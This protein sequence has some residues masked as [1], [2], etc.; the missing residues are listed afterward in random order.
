MARL[1]YID[2][3]LLYRYSITALYNCSYDKC[4]LPAEQFNYETVFPELSGSI[5][6][7]AG[8][9]V[10]GEVDI[11]RVPASFLSKI[12]KQEWSGENIVFDNSLECINDALV[13]KI[14][15]ISARAGIP[16]QKFF[17][18]T[19]CFNPV[20][21]YNNLELPPG[22]R[23]NVAGISYWEYRFNTN[24]DRLYTTGPKDRLLLCF[25]RRL[26]PHRVLLISKLL[27][28]D[29]V[30]RSLI[31]FSAQHISKSG[32][33]LSD[34]PVFEH[35][36]NILDAITQ[37]EA[38][39]ILKEYWDIFPLKLN[40]DLALNKNYLDSDDIELYDRSYFS[41]VTETYFFESNRPIFHTEKIFKP[42]AM[43]HPFIVM[44]V[45]GILDAFKQL[46]YRSFHPYI[47]ETYDTVE[48]NLDRFNCITA[49]IE[50]LSKFTDSEWIEWQ[51]NIQ[52]IVEFNY[53][54]LNKR[55]SMPVSSIVTQRNF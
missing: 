30:N 26:A 39:D 4:K 6:F 43:R 23:C 8:P 18:I 55:K 35:C 31:S 13:L 37:P 53:N 28:M 17:L 20:T 19:G 49:E 25:N 15:D 45:K 41:L 21:V 24:I 9:C 51:K 10:H 12:I 5:S 48:N 54:L 14:H 42:V 34:I 40:T 11:I 3:G 33:Y 44:G 32:K 46:G 1:E 36:A 22:E 16:L 29:L 27:E 7:Y 50:R 52:E 47:D 38:A 2:A